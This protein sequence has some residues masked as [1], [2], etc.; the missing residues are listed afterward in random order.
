MRAGSGTRSVRLWQPVTVLVT[1][2]DMDALAWV[3]A[4]TP[5]EARFYINTAHWLNNTY[6][7]VDGGGWLLPYTGRWAL[8]PTVFYGY[9]P[10]VEIR[11]QVRLWGE[12][13]SSITT[14]AV[15]TFS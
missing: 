15:R 5:E 8:V 12:K 3:E 10:D 6:R 2:A 9:S 14:R 7:G 13:A 4:N 11:R 1:E